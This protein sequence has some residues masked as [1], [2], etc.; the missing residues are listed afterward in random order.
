MTKDEAVARL[1]A[2]EGDPEDTHERADRIL[3]DYLRAN[4]GE[5]I[6]AAFEDARAQIGFWY[7]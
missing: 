4:G 1:N 3:L 2:L 6:A 5:A 7:A